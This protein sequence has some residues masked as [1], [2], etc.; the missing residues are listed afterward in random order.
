MAGNAL[1]ARFA[2]RFGSLNLMVWGRLVAFVGAVVLAA[3][4]IALGASSWALFLPVALAEIGDGLT[5]PSV[6]AAAL[7]VHPRIAG[8]ASGLMGFLQMTTAAIGSFLVAL[9]PQTSALGPIAVFA[10]FVALALGFA[11]LA[12]RRQPH[13]V[14]MSAVG[15]VN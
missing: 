6:M 12:L 4:F 3:W 5:Q 15:S 9:L 1:A 10:G 14:A 7:S 11:L 8:T 13:A 2:V